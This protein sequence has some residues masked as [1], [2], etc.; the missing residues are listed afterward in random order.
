MTLKDLQ[1]MAAT[2]PK[3]GKV[4]QRR[5]LLLQ[6]IL[7]RMPESATHAY[8]EARRY[9]REFWT[10]FLTPC[11]AMELAQWR[12]DLLN[13]AHNDLVRD[14]LAGLDKIV[15]VAEVRIPEVI[16]ALTFKYNG[17]EGQF[18]DIWMLTY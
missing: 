12:F 10:N 17:Y 18:I 3:R 4:L 9:N 5:L 13:D 8:N 14:V 7:T 11:V 6:P 2:A 16:Q 1:A 15:Q